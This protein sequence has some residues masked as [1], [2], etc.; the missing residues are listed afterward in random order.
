MDENEH[1]RLYNI[2][3]RPILKKRHRVVF[4]LLHYTVTVIYSTMNIMVYGFCFVFV[5]V[6]VLP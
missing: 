6:F 2:S 3:L 1:E 5:F 4:A